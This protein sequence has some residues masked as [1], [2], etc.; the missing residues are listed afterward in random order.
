MD[1]D[2]WRRLKEIFEAASECP[3]ERRAVLLERMCFGDAELR[4]EA[5][6]LLEHDANVGGFLEGGA[7]GLPY[8]LNEGAVL[9]GRLRI[10]RAL[11]RGG[12]GE[13]YEAYNEHAQQAEA[14]KVLRPELARDQ[15]A[16][17]RVVKE[18]QAAR[19]I[20]HPNVCRVYDLARDTQAGR[21][22]L[23]LT[24]ELL[25]GETLS[26]RL[27]RD[28]PMGAAEAAAIA[29]QIAAGLD[30]AHEA[31]IVHRDFKSA[32]VM[33]AG[34]AEAPRAVVMDFGLAR[35]VGIA[36][37]SLTS[38]GMIV[39]TPAY[40]SPEQLEGSDATA[41]A[42]IYA[43]GIVLHEMR[44]G[45]THA[46]SGATLEREWVDAI[47][48]CMERDP[49]RRPASAEKVVAG[50]SSPAKP[51]R[52]FKPRVAVLSVAAAGLA[53]FW[54]IYRLSG[55]KNAAAAGAPIMLTPIQN[56]TKDT[57]LDA[58]TEVF[59]AQLGQSGYFRLWDQGRLPGVLERMAWPKDKPLGDN[60]RR[61]AAMRD[62]V[63]FVVFGA[64]TPVGGELVLSLRLDEL[65]T[66]TPIARRTWRESF[67]TAD[68]AGLYDAIHEGTLWL[69]ARL[70]EPAAE[71][72]A[73]DRLPQDTTSSSWG[74][75][76]DLAAAERLREA[77]QTESA[78]AMLRD[79]L[80]LD[81]DF[82][83]AHM[84]LG[85]LLVDQ[86]RQQEGLDEW[87]KAMKGTGRRLTRREEL[88]I[89]GECA[90]D[91]WD[92][93]AAEA[94]FVRMEQEYPYEYLASFYL[95]HALEW[96]GRFETAAKHM[97]GAARKQPNSGPVLSNLASIYLHLHRYDDIERAVGQ[98]AAL[99]RA[100]A[101]DRYRGLASFARGKM[102]DALAAFE[103]C[104]QSTEQGVKSRGY[105]EKAALLAELGRYGEARAAL[106]E[107][108]KGDRAAGRPE[109]LGGKEIA[110][111]SLALRDGRKADARVLAWDAANHDSGAFGLLRAAIL[112]ARS[113]AVADAHRLGDRAASFAPGSV[114]NRLVESRIR[115]EE[116]LASGDADGAIAEFHR[117]DAL[118]AAIRPR[119][120]LAAALTAAHRDAEA[121]GYWKAI[122][123]RP[124]LLWQSADFDFP[125]SQ[126][127]ALLEYAKEAGRAGQ[128]EQEQAALK[129]Y[130]ERRGSSK[131]A[132]TAEA[133]KML[134]N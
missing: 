105:S 60:D 55:E 33:L 49:A 125:G 54:G 112:L 23:F 99:P 50:L 98:L 28:G 124:E 134:K 118:D 30:A 4:R 78:M 52:G 32:N 16:A 36:G 103:R 82:A 67:R 68:E 45:S 53:L 56:L 13:V 89:Q 110:L 11:G 44:T 31:G 51:A 106:E 129:Q 91:T 127:D 132:E 107:G 85:D 75:I 20:T 29:R 15:D 76:S 22:L 97:E 10:V 70:G 69:R 24:M 88:L 7:R 79:A 93:P 95:G 17:E 77:R 74:A 63:P 113:G 126:T 84:R 83:L 71:V 18:V 96:Q 34:T 37:R 1:A 109:L 94:A 115:G 26:E 119:E 66:D 92:F 64:I 123:E 72:G 38:T 62:S 3:P 48:A 61:E 59:R 86:R 41:A 27:R 65:G 19:R 81:S 131:S 43:F 8:S 46:N 9:A 114:Y 102:D 111:A 35:G 14:V 87:Q 100:T 116:L 128:G 12:M 90:N 121:A 40:M 21:D 117:T 5:E 6:E 80:R 108:M 42:D 47:R 58:A 73:H 122:A 101:A 104:V 25:Q 57:R 133:R 2:R 120:Y 130:L 39:G